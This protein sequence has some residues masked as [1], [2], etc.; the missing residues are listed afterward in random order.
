MK[1]RRGGRW[2]CGEGGGGTGGGNWSG[3][4]KGGGWGGDGRGRR[5]VEGDG[6]G[7]LS[8]ETRMTVKQETKVG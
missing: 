7:P 8:A 4:G 3:E 1:N 6:L 2:A 5:T